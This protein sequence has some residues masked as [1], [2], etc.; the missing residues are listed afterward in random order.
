[1]IKIIN[2]IQYEIEA[3]YQEKSMLTNLFSEHKLWGWIG[4]FIIFFAGCTIF[5]FQILIWEEENKK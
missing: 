3:Q 5:I 2:T 1:M 4:L